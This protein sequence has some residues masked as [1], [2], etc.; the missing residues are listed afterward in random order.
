[1]TADS[2]VRAL[3]GGANQ[4]GVRAHNERL[5]L[6]LIQRHGALPG[7]ELAKRARLSPQTVSVILRSL[8]AEGLVEK[9][10]PQRGQ[11]GK[12]RVPM[13]LRPDGIFSVGLNVGR[14]RAGLVLMD[15][16]GVILD[17]RSLNYAHPTPDAVLDFLARGLA[18]FQARLGP[19]AGRIAGIGVAMP[20][21]IWQWA[22]AIG[23]PEPALRVWDGIDIAAR[24]ARFTDL[25]VFGENDA[26]AACQAEHVF[27]RGKAFS[28]YVY[29]Y[30]GSFIGGGVVLNNSIFRG[31][32]GNAGAL[33]PLPVTRADGTRAQLLDVASLHALEGALRTAGRDPAPMWAERGDWSTLEPHL[34]TWI[35]TTAPHLARMSLAVAAVIDVEAVLIDG[36][37]PDAVRDR[38]LASVRAELPG[39]DARGLVPPRIE[40]GSVGRLAR[41]KGAATA[42]ITARYLLDTHGARAPA[43]P[44]TQGGVAI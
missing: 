5:I 42:P 9:G 15:A 33:G 20:Y 4:Q 17:S 32:S 22:D 13:R 7:S 41:E 34:G 18:C 23:A 40:P 21:M 44:P 3:T 2:G 29:A 10:D 25:P 36:A 28:D 1:M 35:A 27:G 11:V 14:R 24:I 16:C 39:L 8:E 30:V 31:P 38:L 37:F 43:D 6:T 19:D 26:T 12:P